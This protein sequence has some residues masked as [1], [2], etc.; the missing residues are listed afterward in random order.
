[1]NTF[2]AT[3]A[4]QARRYHARADNNR[5]LPEIGR[6]V[7]VYGPRFLWSCVRLRSVSLALWVVDYERAECD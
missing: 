1:M 5:R 4:G 6:A 3:L 2:V 7:W